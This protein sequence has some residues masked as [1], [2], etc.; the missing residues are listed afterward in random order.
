[1]NE[2]QEWLE[3]LEKR[4]TK[5]EKNAVGNKEFKT[6]FSAVPAKARLTSAS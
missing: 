4:I 2:L 5:L 1:M 3:D 6:Y